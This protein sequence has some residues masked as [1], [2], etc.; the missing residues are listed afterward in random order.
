VPYDP[1]LDR[2]LAFFGPQVLAPYREQPDKYEVTTDYFEGKVTLT[3]A[4]Y[5]QLDHAA[6]EREWIDVRFG[7]RTQ[8]NGE[9]AIAAFGPDL[10]DKSPD[11]V[12][13]WRPF[14]IERG[15]WVDYDEDTRF[16]MWVR[17]N[18]E[19]EWDVD[20]GPAFY[21]LEEIKLIN[22]LAREVVDEPLFMADDAAVNYPTG[23]N[24]HRY[25]D[26]HRQ[27]YGLLIDGLSKSCIAALSRRVGRP[28]QTASDRTVDALKAVFRALD[29]ADF[30]TSIANVSE[31]R[32]RASHGVRPP[33]TPMRAF[34]TFSR[35]IEACLGAIRLLRTILEKELQ[36]DAEHAKARQDAIGRLPRIVAPPEPNYSV[37]Q[38]TE[39]AGKTVEK[40]EVGFREQTKNRHLS[41]AM[42]IHFTDGSIMS[43]DTGCNAGSLAGTPHKPQ[44]FHVDLIVQW[45]PAKSPKAQP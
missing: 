5:E 45:V 7:Y 41:E 16:R 10:V 30:N 2:I 36:M 3:A 31:Q 8:K 12:A 35:D 34:E 13:R 9:L 43:V 27:L 39:M 24:T 6:R 1:R 19:G 14:L 37:T 44:E 40:V 17:R 33:A 20:N 4:Y 32:G 28:R 18:I 26:A 25:E 42:I 38:A 23:E 11:H 21:L 15:D 22:G 29:V